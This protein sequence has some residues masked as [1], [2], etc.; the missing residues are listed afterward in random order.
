LRTK[1]HRL[2]TGLSLLLP[3]ASA[4]GFDAIEVR[5]TLDTVAHTMTGTVEV[6]FADL[7]DNLTGLRFRLYPNRL[8]EDTT[9]DLCGILVDSATING[10]NATPGIQA[11]KTDLWVPMPNGETVG[12]TVNCR[13]YFVTHVIEHWGR[14]GYFNGQFTLEAWFPYP[15]PLRDT[16]WL[17]IDYGTY[18]EPSGEHYD[19]NGLITLPADWQVI[20][21]GIRQ[22]D[23]TAGQKQLV[24]ELHP[25]QGIPMIIAHDFELDQRDFNG[26]DVKTYY[27]SAAA[28]ALDTIRNSAIKA[29]AY[30]SEHIMPYPFD[31]LILVIG[32][33]NVSGGLELPRM[34]IASAPERG[35][36]GR[37]H[38]LTMIHEVIHQWFYGIV[39]TDQA[40]QPWMDES[41]TEYFTTRVNRSIAGKRADLG[42][43]FGLTMSYDG[44]HRALGHD[45]LDVFPID[46]PANYYPTPGYFASIYNKGTLVLETLGKVMGEENEWHFWQTYTERYKFRSPTRAD[47]VR[48]AA[49]FMPGV[50]TTTV[51]S[52]ISIN[53]P[54]DYAIR[55]VSTETLGGPENSNDSASLPKG[56]NVTVHYLAKHPPPF[57]VGLRLECI[58]GSQLDTLFVARNGV[59]SVVFHTLSLPLSAE[60]DPGGTFAIDENLLN[61]SLRFSGVEGAGPR[62]LSGATFLVESLIST[63]WGF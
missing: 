9:V 46:R 58:D 48:T 25:A 8:C 32:G 29:M 4:A 33:L 20:A 30:M 19:I 44:M 15:A 24:I 47:F 18:A 34:V 60:I 49:E 57:P 55:G 59:D 31:E 38:Q 62:I 6:T 22:I 35:L 40:L 14:F 2:L 5:A 42:D 61:N 36:I 51:S 7:P 52:L 16:G 63:L 54:V 23:S 11:D 13:L 12:D 17:A 50:D 21:P 27:R 10:A 53:D 37:M 1:W 26:V 3:L 45:V 43:L 28:F 56:Y 39:A 41:I